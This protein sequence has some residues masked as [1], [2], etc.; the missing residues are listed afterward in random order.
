M[1]K[2]R[3]DHGKDLVRMMKDGTIQ[4]DVLPDNGT[5][6]H[7]DYEQIYLE[8]FMDYLGSVGR[9]LQNERLNVEPYK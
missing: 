6:F 4:K 1:I 5:E 7:G 8:T 2:Y 9:Y 3:A